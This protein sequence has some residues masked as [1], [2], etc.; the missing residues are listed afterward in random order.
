MQALKCLEIGTLMG[1][2]Y[3]KYIDGWAKKFERIYV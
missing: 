2:F 3:P 1:Y